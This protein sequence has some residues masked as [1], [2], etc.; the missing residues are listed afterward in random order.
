MSLLV[1]AGLF[2]QTTVDIGKDYAGDSARVVI[3]STSG[4]NFESGKQLY[5]FNAEEA[6]E[7]S[8]F[9][10]TSEAA[11]F[12]A[13]GSSN[14]TYYDGKTDKLEKVPYFK[15]KADSY[16]THTYLEI[17]A[18]TQYITKM[19]TNGTQASP[20]KDKSKAIALF[21]DQAP[22][23]PESIT[24]YQEITVGVC[25][26]GDAGFEIIGEDIPAQT[27]SVRVLGAVALM[28]NGS[29]YRFA[30]ADEI[31]ELGVEP[32]GYAFY[33]K[34]GDQYRI[35]YARVELTPSGDPIPASGN[36]KIS[37]ATIG[38][39][40]A[41][42]NN[43]DNTISVSVENGTDISAL[44]VEFTLSNEKATANFTSGTAHNFAT[45]LTIKV[46]AENG[47]VREYTLTVTVLPA[48]EAIA[49]LSANG[50]WEEYDNLLQTVFDGK[51]IL[52]LK[53]ET[54][55]PTDIEAFYAG[56]NMIFIHANVG[57]TNATLTATRTMVGKLPILNMKVY[58][59]TDDKNKNRW[60][61]S[62]ALDNAGIGVI[63]S[64]VETALQ[65]HN[66]FTGLTF[67]G[68]S[69]TYY[70]QPTTVVNG[71]QLSGAFD[72]ANWT[73]ELEAAN[74][75]LATYTTTKLSTGG[76]H[77]HE[78]NLSNAAKYIMI[79]LS[80]EGTPSSYTFFNDNTITMLKN[81]I[82]Y[83][84]NP[85]SY[86]DYANN[87][88]VTGGVSIDTPEAAAP[89]I[90]FNGSDIINPN[91]EAVKI[92]NLSGVMVLSSSLETISASELPSGV[93]VAVSESGAKKFAK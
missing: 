93:Y 57:G 24:G 32:S 75:V 90:Y 74:H 63:S 58:S 62:T 44:P 18:T 5:T 34:A 83:L 89:S 37:A 31:T 19:K 53:A 42:I 52:H 36:N 48:G 61:W 76:T 33:F 23:N 45:P 59:Y 4:V 26:N 13:D 16:N 29:K 35:A 51:K 78:I 1:C 81:S 77:I 54:A 21:S 2:A 64:K 67:N 80:M 40:A 49:I 39:K 11:D 70:S 82:E 88:P 38:G 20:T 92:Y 91:G 47:D 14:G 87:K 15:I 84:L 50:Q 3:P 86:Y 8:F 46:T 73:A 72:G 30:T 55:A 43:T 10:Q 71:I 68:D 17:T 12:N 60:L 22:F 6:T 9:F 7:V 69:L 56:C 27:R 65:N 79:G 85:G 28:Q 25:R 66:I 41:A